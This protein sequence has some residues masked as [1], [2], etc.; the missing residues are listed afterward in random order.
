MNH[1]GCTTTLLVDDYFEIYRI[2]SLK[3]N[4]LGETRDYFVL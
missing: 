4:L 1:D 3:E 2:F